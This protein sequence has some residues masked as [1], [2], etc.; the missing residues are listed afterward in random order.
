MD[1]FYC[2]LFLKKFLSPVFSIHGRMNIECIGNLPIWGRL[3]AIISIHSMCI[4][5]KVLIYSSNVCINANTSHFFF[6]LLKE[7]IP[8][9]LMLLCF[10]AYFWVWNLSLWIHLLCKLLLMLK[11]NEQNLSMSDCTRE[12]FRL[13]IVTFFIEENRKK[14]QWEQRA[15]CL[16]NTIEP[17]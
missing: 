10:Y 13:Q 17:V 5:E 7:L 1:V 2:S 4:Q 16:V 9:I 6:F 11:E 14:Y 12:N 15:M 8:I 3:V